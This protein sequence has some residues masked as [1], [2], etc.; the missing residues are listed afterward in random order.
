M[1]GNKR[2]GLRPGYY[3][4]VTLSEVSE[5]AKRYFEKNGQALLRRSRPKSRV[6]TKRRSDQYR[7]TL[8]D[9]ELQRD[10][11]TTLSDEGIQFHAP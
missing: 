6:P 4:L 10:Q 3:T 5:V 9:R 2:R 1:R 7:S 11:L 8:S